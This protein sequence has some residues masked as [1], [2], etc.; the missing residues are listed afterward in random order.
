[1]TPNSLPVLIICGI[2]CYAGLSRLM[3]FVLR[4]ESRVNLYFAVVCFSIAFY[5]AMAVGLYNSASVE[6][7]VLWQRGQFY[8]TTFIGGSFFF[9]IFALFEKRFVL[10]KLLYLCVLAAFLALGL[11]FPQLVVSTTHPNARSFAF[12][13]SLVRYFEGA[14]GILFNLAN[15]WLVVGMV[16]ILGIAVSA[17]RSRKREDA[18]FIL[19][20][21][22][23]FFASSF[24]DILIA[25]NLILSFYSAEYA[26]L[27]LI[28][29]MDLAVQKRFV[30]L[31]REVEALNVGLE[32]RVERRTQEISG[33]ASQ[34]SSKNAELQ[35]KNA[36][37]AELADRDG[38]T[39]LLNHAAFHRRLAEE[40]S[41]ARRQLF[42]LSLIMIDIDRFKEI[43]DAYGHQTGDKVILK[44]AEILM[45]NS[46]EYDV[47]AKLAAE[48][49]AVKPVGGSPTL[50]LH[51][52]PGRYGGDEFALL[53]PYCGAAD[54]LVIAER[55]RARI[56][57][58]A[59]PGLPELRVGASLGCAVFDPR[60]EGDYPVANFMQA[61][62]LAL[63]EAK[64]AGRGRTSISKGIGGV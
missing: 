31:F 59:I 34:L 44:V 37:L 24:L 4:K 64:T 50:Y 43:N 45:R 29:M 61:A 17:A 28:I 7:G 57:A 56:E 46:R 58:I 60:A 26:F 22:G 12:L 18:F 9:M 49:D 2:S 52:V 15:L 23:F 51:D 35:D 53:L 39:K 30:S 14:T 11:A 5:D 33:L 48:A 8:S 16:Y 42:C 20:G 63:Y 32:A 38:L 36:V 27:A 19:A 41:A 54:V 6:A 13:G 62:D 55:V 10:F 25:S 1:M 47:K 40:F 3:M 21:L